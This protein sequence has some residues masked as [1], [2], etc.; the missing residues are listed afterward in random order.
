[1]AIQNNNAAVVNF[2]END[3][4]ARVYLQHFKIRTAQLEVKAA[5]I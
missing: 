3:G 2:V 1:M 4:E 5:L